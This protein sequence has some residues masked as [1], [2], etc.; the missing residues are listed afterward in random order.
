MHFLTLL[1]EHLNCVSFILQVPEEVRLAHI[2]GCSGHQKSERLRLP[3][4]RERRETW[5]GAGGHEG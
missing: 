1:F 2:P 5:A 3:E 4:L